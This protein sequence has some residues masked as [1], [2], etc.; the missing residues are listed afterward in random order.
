MV[1]SLGGRELFKLVFRSVTSFIVMISQRRVV[2]P[3]LSLKAQCGLI[4]DGMMMGMDYVSR[5]GRGPWNQKHC[6]G[7]AL[8]RINHSFIQSRSLSESACSK[9]P[10]PGHLYVIKKYRSGM[11]V[12][13]GR[14]KESLSMPTCTTNPASGLNS[15]G[16]LPPG[17]LHTRKRLRKAVSQV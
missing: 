8:I 4:G 16:I 17:T 7:C 15:T 11:K 13:S 1:I 5:T 12:G 2:A 9:Q 14:Q 10:C 6:V 3:S